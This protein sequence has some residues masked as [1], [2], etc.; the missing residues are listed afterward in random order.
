VLSLCSVLVFDLSFV[1]YFSA[2]TDVNATVWSICADVPL[3]ICSVTHSRHVHGGHVK[4]TVSA[5]SSL[6]YIMQL[7]QKNDLCCFGCVT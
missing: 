7:S 2:Y 5:M 1:T 3:R 6:Y 4:L